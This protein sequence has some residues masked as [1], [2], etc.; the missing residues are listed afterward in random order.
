MAGRQACMQGVAVVVVVFGVGQS[1]LS[2]WCHGP[3]T[4]APA[5]PTQGQAGWGVGDR[6]IAEDRRRELGERGG[7]GLGGR[8]AWLQDVATEP[9]QRRRRTKTACL[10]PLPPPSLSFYPALSLHPTLSPALPPIAIFVRRT[11]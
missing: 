6:S 9:P 3:V 2:Q 4:S 5:A 7:G 8:P 1:S 10:R 11:C